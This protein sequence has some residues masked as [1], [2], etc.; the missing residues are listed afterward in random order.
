MANDE[1]WYIQID[2]GWVAAAVSESDG[3]MLRL[4]AF[5]YQCYEKYDSLGQILVELAA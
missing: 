2:T 3:W 1:T 4:S 5:Y